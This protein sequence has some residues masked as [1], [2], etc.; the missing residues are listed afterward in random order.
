MVGEVYILSRLRITI[1]YLPQKRGV[2]GRL[3]MACKVSLTFQ[4]SG[5]NIYQENGGS[6]LI[7]VERERQ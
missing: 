2:S 6:T 7:A 3:W 1:R 5:E 4:G